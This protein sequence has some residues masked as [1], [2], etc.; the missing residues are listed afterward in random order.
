[1]KKAIV[2]QALLITSLAVPSVVFA[3]SADV[4]KIQNFIESI[5]QV[6]VTLAGALA[7]VF[8]VVGGIRYITSTGNPDALDQAKK[9]LVYSG[10]GISVAVGAL[11]LSN[12]VTQLAQNAFGK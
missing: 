4:A 10:V 5:I 7:A 1:M 2:L 9:T 11:V 6:L 3:Q 12:I 8:F